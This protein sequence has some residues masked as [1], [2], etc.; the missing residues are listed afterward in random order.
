MLLIQACTSG[1]GPGRGP[2]GKAGALLCLR[3]E[4]LAEGKH[5][6]MHKTGRVRE[7]EPDGAPEARTNS[8]TQKH[9]YT[10]AYTHTY[11]HTNPTYYS[12]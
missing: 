3:Q 7:Q 9:T 10:H 11:I 4:R 2:R 6:G 5:Q 1:S 8:A 12:H